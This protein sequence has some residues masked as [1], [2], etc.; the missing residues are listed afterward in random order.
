MVSGR[1]KPQVGLIN[2]T[3]LLSTTSVLEKGLPQSASLDL[4]SKG[5]WF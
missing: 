1:E 3:A 5:L 2:A 4:L